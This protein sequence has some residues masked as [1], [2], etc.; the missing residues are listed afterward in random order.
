[1]LPEN[2]SDHLLHI[3]S[4]FERSA[5]AKCVNFPHED[6]SYGKYI[7]LL[8]K[9]CSDEVYFCSHRDSKKKKLNKIK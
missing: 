7:N 1:M 6:I 3:L 8:N 5:G 9:D 4:E 2:L